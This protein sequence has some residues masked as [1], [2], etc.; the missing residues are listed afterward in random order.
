MPFTFSDCVSHRYRLK[1][2]V[3]YRVFCLRVEM[4]EDCPRLHEL[5]LIDMHK[6][7]LVD[8]GEEQQ[9]L[10]LLVKVLELLLSVLMEF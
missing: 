8:V 5:T 6:V 3:D 9:M 10:R 1:L 4:I 7:Q 2:V